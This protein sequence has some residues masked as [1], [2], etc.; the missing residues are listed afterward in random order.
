M[1]IVFLMAP[2]AFHRIVERGEDTERL[3]RFA[4]A[5]VLAAMVP[6][7]L[8]IAGDFYI[9]LAKV[10]DSPG[11][12]VGLAVVSLLVFFGLWFG[13]TL[14]VRTRVEASRGALRVSR[15]VR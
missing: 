2:A 15:A 8:G 9:V 1:T 6:L 12:A 3:H 4:S 7:A 11:V 13:L 5:M 10:L 14:A